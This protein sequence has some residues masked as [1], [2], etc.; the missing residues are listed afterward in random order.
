MFGYLFKHT[1]VD[2]VNYVGFVEGHGSVNP[3]GGKLL[4]ENYNHMSILSRNS[5]ASRRGIKML[6]EALLTLKN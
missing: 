4:K 5:N 6:D 1:V 3:V 2:A